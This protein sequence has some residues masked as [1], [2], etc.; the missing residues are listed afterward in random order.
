M[1]AVNVLFVNNDAKS[2]D[3]QN[4]IYAKTKIAFCCC[5]YCF[6]GTLYNYECAPSERRKSENKGAHISQNK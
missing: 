6:V 1:F 3:E 5:Y 4:C 2:V